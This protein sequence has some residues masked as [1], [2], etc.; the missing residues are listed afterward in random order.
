VTI[1]RCARLVPGSVVGAL[2]FRTLVWVPHVP[3]TVSRIPDSCRLLTTSFANRSRR[4]NRRI[5]FSAIAG[6]G[7]IPSMLI[8]DSESKYPLF[9]ALEQQN[10]ICSGAFHLS[11]SLRLAMVRVCCSLFVYVSVET[12]CLCVFGQCVIS[13]CSDCT[14]CVLPL[15]SFWSQQLNVKRLPRVTTRRVIVLVGSPV[16]DSDEELVESAAYFTKHNIAYVL[17]SLSLSLSLSLSVT[18]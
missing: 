8:V 18:N 17:S 16:T 6:A 10:S 1:S 9:E 14:T 13:S 11:W 7:E 4:T 3:Q 12:V 5:G 15:H 2:V